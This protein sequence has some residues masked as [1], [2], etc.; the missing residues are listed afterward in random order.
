MKRQLLFVLA[1]AVWWAARSGP[2]VAAHEADAYCGD[3]ICQTISCS[4]APGD[5]G[6]GCEEDAGNCIDCQ[7][8]PCDNPNPYWVM[9]DSEPVGAFYQT[10]SDFGGDYCENVVTVLETFEDQQTCVS[11]RQGTFSGC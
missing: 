8:D 10:G 5:P 1:V 4:H 9:T 2:P 7:V 11:A 6:N 3:G